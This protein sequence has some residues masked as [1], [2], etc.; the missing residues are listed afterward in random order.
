MKRI[1]LIIL[2]TLLGLSAGAARA[3]VQGKLSVGTGYLEHP[4]GIM[5][6]TDALYTYQNLNLASRLAGLGGS[7]KLGYEGQA[8]QFGSDTQLGSQR[9]GLGAEY[10]H[11]SRSRMLGWSAGVQGAI[12]RQKEWYEAYDQDEIF[13]YAAFKRYTGGN[14]LWKGFA[15]YRIRQYGALPEENSREPHAQF[16]VLRF[17]PTQTSLGLRLSYGYKEYHDE[18][19]PSVWGTSTTPSTSQ[20][21]ARLSFSKSLSERAGLRA[22]AESRWKLEEFPHVIADDFY[23]SPILDRYA[24]EGYDLYTALKVLA[25]YQWWVETGAAY[26]VHDYGEIV[27]P[28]ESGA[29][30]NREDTLTELHLSLQRSLGAALRGAR[31]NI[32]GGWRNQDS[33][34]VWYDY[35]GVFFSSN[36]GWKF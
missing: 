14:M 11:L 23:D 5:T 30:I 35:S 31:L 18:S 17:S 9:H 10:Y 12:R 28:S 36:L 24:N 13:A 27:F 15:G 26:G 1:S 3:Q 25:P 2:I 7:L 33:T 34:H 16:E 21:A 29:G 20:L 32:L 19:A 22:W 8:S 4:V 6:E